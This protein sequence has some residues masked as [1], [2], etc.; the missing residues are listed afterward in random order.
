VSVGF[1]SHPAALAHEMPD[2]HP[3]RAERIAAITTHLER[4]GILGS[5]ERH[6]PQPAPRELLELVH[7]A[8]LVEVLERLDEQGGGR[9]DLDTSMGPHSLDAARRGSQGA[10]DAADRVLDG[11][12]SAAFVCMRPPGH[13][14][15]PQRSMGFC[16]TNHAAIAARHAITSGRAA[17]V[18]ILDW[19]AH[20]GNGTQDVFWTDPGVLYVSLHQYPWYPGT[21]DVTECGEGPGTGTTLNIPLPSGAAEDA[22]DRAFADVIEPAV[23]DFR[24]DLVIVS[25]GFDAHHLDPL[26]MLRLTAGAFHRMT[27]RAA[28]WGPG[29]VCVL[30]GGYDLDAL[31]WSSAAM[32]SALLGREPEGM[33]PD[34][35]GPLPGHPDALRWVERAAEVRRGGSGR[36]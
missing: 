21:G 20:H 10:V 16:H 24:P 28:G 2:G 32:L 17:R 33:P 27:V 36:P 7:D 35:A 30:E 14:A 15:T 13:H 26:C 11:T 23:A 6:E 5:L 4:H 8:R 18:V 12:W 31:A 9:I 19:D 25:A 34:E 1:V 29:P 3:E 22:F